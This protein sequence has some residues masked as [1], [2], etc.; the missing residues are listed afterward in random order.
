MVSRYFR[1]YA[2]DDA[3]AIRPSLLTIQSHPDGILTVGSVR[4]INAPEQTSVH[5][6]FH[7]LTLMH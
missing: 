6:Q 3:V 7:A 1:G 2:I 4:H 5:V